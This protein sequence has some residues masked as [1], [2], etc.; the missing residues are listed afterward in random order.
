MGVLGVLLAYGCCNVAGCVVICLSGCWF[1]WFAGWWCFVSLL[2]VSGYDA[3]V[4]VCCWVYLLVV[5]FGCLFI[6]ALGL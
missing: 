2:I 6:A 1:G 4:P 3:L 5:G